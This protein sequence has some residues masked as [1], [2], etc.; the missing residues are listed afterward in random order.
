MW[1]GE[2]AHDEGRVP[3]SGALKLAL[4]AS[5]LGVLVLGVAP[6]LLIRLAEMATIP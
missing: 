1:L 6:Y 3:A 4:A 2:P 5:S